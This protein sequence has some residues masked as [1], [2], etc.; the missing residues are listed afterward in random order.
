MT[1]RQDVTLIKARPTLYRGIRM[2]SRLEADYA[3]ALDRQE[4]AWEYE[5]ECFA[6][7]NGQWLPD[8]RVQYG[9]GHAL[10]ELKPLSILDGEPADVVHTIDPLL[11]RMTIAWASSPGITLQLAVWQYGG[12]ERLVLTCGDEHDAWIANFEHQD[13]PLLW[14]GM[15]QYQRLMTGT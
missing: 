9:G 4:I 1:G 7:R 3:A 15:G 13:F 11:Q 14:L 12:P 2:R 8:F 10:I 6:S 5:P